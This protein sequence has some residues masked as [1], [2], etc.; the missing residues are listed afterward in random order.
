MIDVLQVCGARL[1]QPPCFDGFHDPLHLG[2]GEE[3]LP[4]A[5]DVSD[6]PARQDVWRQL[7]LQT[8]I[9]SKHDD[10]IHPFGRDPNQV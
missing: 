5:L 9:A 1:R 2:L 8:A 7:R 3:H 6:V 4:L 10:G